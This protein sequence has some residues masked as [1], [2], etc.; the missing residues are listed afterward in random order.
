MPR[1]HARR[2][3]GARGHP[4]ERKLQAAAMGKYEN[5]YSISPDLFVTELEKDIGEIS[6]Q[7]TVLEQALAESAETMRQLAEA[8]LEKQTQDGAAVAAAKRWYYDVRFPNYLFSNV[9]ALENAN[10]RIKRWVGPA[11]T[12][13][14][15][16]MIDRSM[17][18]ELITTVIDFISNA[19]RDEFV[20]LV[21]DEEV[22]WI[23]ERQGVYSAI[24]PEDRRP[25]LDARTRLALGP[26][27][28]AE[29][30][31]PAPGDLRTLWFSL[32]SI[33]IEIL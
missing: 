4:A 13:E 27:P 17:Q 20:L 30:P 5:L 7:Q 24:I 16:V 33:G 18:Y 15:S 12:L 1:L 19:V 31:A 9:Y 14:F 28:T 3:A 8:L 22:P 11:R 25:R 26:R 32:A 6:K 29:A 23:S 2:Q 21:D 10:D